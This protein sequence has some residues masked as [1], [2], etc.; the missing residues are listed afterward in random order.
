MA[1]NEREL[2]ARLVFETDGASVNKATD[3]V[4]GLNKSIEDTAKQAEAARQKLT[5]LKESAERLKQVGMVMAGMGAAILAPLAAASKLYLDQA[6]A[7]KEAAA[8]GKVLT[9]DQQKMVATA[10]RW[11]AANQRVQA[12]MGR[13][14]GI[15]VQEV[16]PYLE[17]AAALM[18]RFA[19]FAEAN[20]GIIKAAGAIGG[21]LIAVGGLITVVGTIAGF[22]A[23]IGLLFG[24]GGMLAGIATIGPAIVAALTPVLAAVAP[25]AIAV[26]MLIA[27]L[28]SQAGQEAILA[29]KK[30]VA[31]LVGGLASIF[32]GVEGGKRAFLEAAKAMD[33]VT[34]AEYDNARASMTAQ[35][36]IKTTSALQVQAATQ[37]ISLWQKIV[38]WWKG[39]VASFR[40]SVPTGNRATGGYAGAGVYSLGEKGRE[41]VMSSSTTKAAESA[42]GGSLSQ[43]AM[44]RALNKGGVNYTDNRRFDS[45]ITAEDRQAMRRDTQSLILGLLG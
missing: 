33:L 2:V 25:V 38:E 43:T 20:P 16:L 35:S 26:G 39:L 32:G 9:A 15:V 4:K 34:Q 7:L 27:L 8:A 18:E 13:I 21:I 30:L 12:A 42:I 5:K 28:K 10:D 41:F 29:G 37:S 19:A 17:Q 40:P 1:D 3:G 24:S 23:N 6:K 22:I 11:N 44:L 31:M 45:R 14:G 36:A